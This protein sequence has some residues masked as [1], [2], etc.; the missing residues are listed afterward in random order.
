MECGDLRIDYEITTHKPDLQVR[1]GT[2]ERRNNDEK[3]RI[4]RV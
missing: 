1:R 4:E 2:Y 3:R